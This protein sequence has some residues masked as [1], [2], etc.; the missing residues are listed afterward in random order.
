MLNVGVIGAGNMGKNHI[1]NY[2][3]MGD[4]NLVG[5]ADIDKE[6]LQEYGDK[7]NVKTFTNYN[8]L[9]PLID[10]VSVVVPT[11]LHKNVVVDCLNNGVDCL[12]EKPI[13]SNIKDANE[14]VN[15]A[16]KNDRILAVGHI[17]NFNP[18]I[19]E[20]KNLIRTGV[21]GKV[22]MIST[23]RLGPFVSRIT[24][25]GI[26]LDSASHD[27]AAIKELLN[28]K[29]ANDLNISS[30]WKGLNNERGDYAIIT[31]KFEDVL[32]N[33]EVNW[34]T[35]YKLREMIITGTESVVKLTY[36]DQTVI[37][38]KLDTEEKL[39]IIKKEPLRLELN[40]FIYA[41]THRTKPRIN[42]VDGVDILKIAMKA[43]EI[44]EINERTVT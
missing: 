11:M 34:Y 4:V 41:V 42:G 2:H 6:L 14:M 18:V 36:Y 33:V 3:E 25:V 15:T 8:D 37:I 23:R 10:A 16:K 39:D 21:L 24:D 44:G 22:L 32:I 19:S 17:E 9:L 13:T 38:Y 1:R 12:V 28:I 40:D 31:M 30:Y 27:I 7:Y 35:P 43:D 20:V 29:S 5:I 26:I